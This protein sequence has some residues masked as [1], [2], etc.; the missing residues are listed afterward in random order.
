MM[1]AQALITVLST[2]GGKAGEI[3]ALGLTVLGAGGIVG[4]LAET[5]TYR[6]LFPR[7]FDPAKALVVSAAIVLSALQTILGSD[8]LRALRSRR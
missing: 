7:T 2:T 5:I 3:G 4:V 8:R 6:V 1:A